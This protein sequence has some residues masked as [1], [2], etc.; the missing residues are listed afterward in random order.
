MDPTITAALFGALGGAARAV[1][2]LCKALAQKRRIIWSYWLLTIATGAIIGATTGSIINFDLRFAALAG[3]AGS[4]LLEGIYKTF[5][6][7]KII[8][9]K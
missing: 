4:D 6:A 5:K 8:I 2:G 3:Y 7:Q 9:G 1:I